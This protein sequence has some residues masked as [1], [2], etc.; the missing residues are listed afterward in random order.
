MKIHEL[1]GDPGRRQKRKRVGRGTGSGLGK[2]SGKGHKGHQARQGGPGG[3][4]SS[5]FEGGQ[6][7]LTRR[8]PKR[9]FNNPFRIEY[10]VVNVGQLNAFDEGSTVDAAALRAKGLI[11]TTRKPVKLLSDGALERKLT[12]KVDRAS[13]TAAEAVTAKGGSIEAEIGNPRAKNAPRRKA[14][15][16]AEAEA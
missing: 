15:E 7:P 4:N 12:V 8:L 10:Q 14:A 11:G 9:G 16:G 1:P 2:T 3:G 5:R 6:T 13:K